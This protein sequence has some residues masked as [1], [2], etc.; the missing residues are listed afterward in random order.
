[1][2]QPKIDDYHEL[3]EHILGDL[4][5]TF[6]LHSNAVRTSVLIVLAFMAGVAA[7]NIDWTA[8][9]HCYKL[10]ATVAEL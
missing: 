8:E 4:F 1:M 6:H 7:I 5:H 9:E 2:R 3:R 10:M